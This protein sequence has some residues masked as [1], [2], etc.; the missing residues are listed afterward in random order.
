MHKFSSIDI[1]YFFIDY[2]SYLCKQKS[3]RQQ[4]EEEKNSLLITTI[5]FSSQNINHLSKLAS[6]GK[7]TSVARENT[8]KKFARRILQ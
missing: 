7:T 1:V 6:I 4:T 5:Y 2:K 3:L 8:K